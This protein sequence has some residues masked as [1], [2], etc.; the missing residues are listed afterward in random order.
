MSGDVLVDDGFKGILDDRLVDDDHNKKYYVVDVT[1]SGCLGNALFL[2]GIFGGGYFGLG[3]W[4]GAE[5]P[6]VLHA[7]IVCIVLVIIGWALYAYD[8]N[9]YKQEAMK[10]RK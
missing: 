8:I 1:E 7:L 4:G 5:E 10:H 2:I 6:W 9:T 3:V